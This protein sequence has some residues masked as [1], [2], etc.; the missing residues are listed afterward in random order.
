[1]TRLSMLR[2]KPIICGEKRIG[3]LQNV[4]MDDAQKKV[5]ALIVS[6]GI[7]GR[8]AVYAED[9]ISV[10]DGFIL[11]EKAFPYNAKSLN[12]SHPFIRD[13]S[14]LLLGKVMDYAIDEDTLNII[15]VELIGG[16]MPADYSRKLWIYKYERTNPSVNELFISSMFGSDTTE[17]GK[18]NV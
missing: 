11:A 13:A 1:M 2:N 15:A 17:P 16:Y 10:C 3:L 18:E 6:C 8:K 9:V 12:F 4:M 5:K 14:G 7:R